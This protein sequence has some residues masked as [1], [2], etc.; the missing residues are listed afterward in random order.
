MTSE[1]GP[2]M[3]PENLGADLGLSTRRNALVSTRDPVV[4]PN[5][6]KRTSEN[7]ELLLTMLL[8]RISS[9]R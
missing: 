4:G 9:G 6:L 1:N 3:P 5:G 2:Q 8:I 7:P